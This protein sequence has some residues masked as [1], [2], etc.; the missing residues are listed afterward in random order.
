MVLLKAGDGTAFRKLF[1]FLSKCQ[2]I[3]ADGHYNLLD[4][5]E[6]ICTV[7]SKLPLH[8]QD[9]WNRNTLQLR[10]KF[11]KETHLIDLTN[12]VEDEMTLVNDLFIHAM[13][14]I[15]MLTGHPDTV[16]KGKERRTMQW[17]QW[18]IILATYFM[19]RVIKL[20]H[21]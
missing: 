19:I 2:T 21:R 12:F 20:R 16:K 5:P 1:N 3:E 7:L 6:I 13:L 9:R 8:L 4:T 14:L 11:S 17:Q 15:S 18:L 10:R